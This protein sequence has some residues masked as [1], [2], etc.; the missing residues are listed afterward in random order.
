MRVCGICAAED[1]ELFHS[2]EQRDRRAWT[3]RLGRRMRDKSKDE[4]VRFVEEE[5]KNKMSAISSGSLS[6]R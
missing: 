2:V 6:V 5:E 4:T 3:L 1:N